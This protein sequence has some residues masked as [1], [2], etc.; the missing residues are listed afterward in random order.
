MLPVD[1]AAGEGVRGET[2]LLSID[3]SAS[4]GEMVTRGGS[5]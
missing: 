2:G 5:T 4:A 3:A 1:S